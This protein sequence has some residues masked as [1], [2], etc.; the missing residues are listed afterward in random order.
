[1]LPKDIGT[2]YKQYFCVGTR[3]GLSFFNPFRENCCPILGTNLLETGVWLLETGVACP[4]NGTAL[5]YKR[6]VLFGGCIAPGGGIRLTPGD[7]LAFYV[8][9][10]FCF[11]FLLF[12]HRGRFP[13]A[14]WHLLLLLL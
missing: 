6:A 8:L 5:L 11:V 1:M 4:Q 7:K 10:L 9:F 13:V 3:G 12:C 14:G 2:N